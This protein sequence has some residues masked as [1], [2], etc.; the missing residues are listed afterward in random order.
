VN[1]RAAQAVLFRET[2]PLPRWAWFVT[3]SP[4]I[5]IFFA[6]GG[7]VQEAIFMFL[8]LLFLSL[9]F[10]FARQITEVREDGVYLDSGTFATPVGW[11]WGFKQV[12]AHDDVRSVISQSAPARGSEGF[13]FSFYFFGEPDISRPP[14]GVQIILKNGTKL[15]FESRRAAELAQA[16]QERLESR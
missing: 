9:L 4:F 13:G 12:V 16:I 10:I 3:Y 11:R 6:A 8:L 5:L 15:W 14:R 7:D 1:T 2:Q